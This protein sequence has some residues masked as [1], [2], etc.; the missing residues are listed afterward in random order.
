MKQKQ[1]K[2]IVLEGTDGTGK[3]TQLALLKA[4]LEKEG[5]SFR[6]DAFPHHG[7]PSAAAVDLYLSQDIAPADAFGP[8]CASVYYA[9]DRSFR[10]F[11]IAGWLK[12]VDIVLLD[13]YVGSN[14][15][16]QGGKIKNEKEREEFLAWLYDLEYNRLGIARPDLNVILHL[17]AEVAQKRKRAQKLALA[18]AVLDAHEED[19]GH[20]KAAEESYL[21]LSWK[22]P[23]E[24]VVVS[25]MEG[26]RELTP[27]EVHERVWKVLEKFL[28]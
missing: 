25:E 9:V 17:P 1:G 7:D 26:E 6:S 8:Y 27:E 18:G 4:R 19:L 24:Y 5:V 14:A 3:A 23:E 16:H 20:L 21:W 11:T 2:L 22:N 15:G 13:R 28:R 12:E 10:K